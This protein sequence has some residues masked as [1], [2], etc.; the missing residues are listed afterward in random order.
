MHYFDQ[1]TENRIKFFYFND[2]YYYLNHLFWPNLDV[3]MCIPTCSN[4]LI[5]YYTYM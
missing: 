3:I 1:T 4:T 5:M 2:H